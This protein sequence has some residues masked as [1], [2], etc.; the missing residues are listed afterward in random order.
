MIAVCI[1]YCT[2][3]ERR[4][5]FTMGFIKKGAIKEY[6]IGLL[7]GL[8]MF[9]TVYAI[10]IISGQADFNGF[11]VNLS[12]PMLALFLIGFMI[13]GMSEEVL[14]RGHYFVSAAAGGNIPLAVFASS[15]FFAIF[16]L[17]NN[18]VSIIAILNRFLF[19]L[20]AAI[21]FLRRGSI[22][23]IGAIHTMWNF[24]QGNIFGTEVSGN[25]MGC[26]VITTER[27][28]GSTLI[29]GGSFGPEG[30]LGVTIVLFIGIV[31]LL[32]MKNKR[33][34][35]EIDFESSF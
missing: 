26:S 33:V 13:Q 35:P 14:L 22:W 20:F 8:V 28:E 29:N 18:G 6:L 23:G 19:G 12:I 34:M 15:A 17:G 25:V 32:F 10:L 11:N 31:I 30:G 4:R 21:Y 27:V 2:K 16:H 24:A 7:I 3:M 1:Y 9:S 5:L